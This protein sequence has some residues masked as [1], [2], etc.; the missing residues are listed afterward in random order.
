VSK[1]TQAVFGFCHHSN[2]VIVYC[3]LQYYVSTYLTR[4][5]TLLTVEVEFPCTVNEVKANKM[6]HANTVVSAVNNEDGVTPGAS[7]S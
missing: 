6:I 3:T 4:A 1:V 2:I 5:S 7:R